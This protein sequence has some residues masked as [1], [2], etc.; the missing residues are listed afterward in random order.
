[1]AE[2]ELLW[3]AGERGN[4]SSVTWPGVHQTFY[5]T[6]DENHKTWK[7]SGKMNSDLD[8]GR[9]RTENNFDECMLLTFFLAFSLFLS[10]DQPE[11]IL[12]I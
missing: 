7:H 6:E 10:S 9:E 4:D 12:L 1:M 2:A 5:L 3:E 11:I 8:M